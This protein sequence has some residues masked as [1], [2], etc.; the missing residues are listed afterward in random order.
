M[1]TLR[2]T[3]RLI[4][5]R[6][7]NDLT[8]QGRRLLEL[9]D[10][11]ATGQRVN[12]PSDDPLA[13]RRAI[14]ATT[15]I[16]A[17]T[18]YITNISTIGPYLVETETA[19]MSSLNL[20]QRARELTLQGASNTNAQAQ[21]DALAEEIDEVLE[22]LLVEAN[23][24]TNDRYV[25]GGTRTLS[26]PFVATRNADDEVTAVA[27]T[28]NS[29]DI[30]IA[31]SEGVRVATNVPGDGVFLST[32]AQSTD[33]FQMLIDIRDNLRA[34]DVGALTTR[35]EEMNFAETQLQVATARLGAV[36]NRIEDVE[37]ELDAYNV[38]L[39]S[40]RS[41]NIDAD[42]AE[43]ILNLNSQSNAFQAALTAGARVL[44]PSLLNFLA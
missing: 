31:I 25:F 12:K 44:Q 13:A 6:I 14:S 18:Q 4:V 2:I 27:Y 34:G 21:R 26:A 41:D 43:V 7:L 15:E 23:H 8:L 29:A 42:F 16:A 3:Q 33:I 38:Q 22:Q 1:G 10:Q 19:I 32:G 5:D 39:E 30:E 37:S 11:L 9:Q 36:T 20:V 24:I 28:G 35:L 17:N 40:V